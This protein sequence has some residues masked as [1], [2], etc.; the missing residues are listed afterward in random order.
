MLQHS[1]RLS[2]AINDACAASA[3]RQEEKSHQN[4]DPRTMA[5]LTEYS[6][7]CE[8]H[9]LIPMELPTDAEPT[10]DEVLAA[11]ADGTMEPEID[12]DDEPKWA[13]TIALPEREYWIA[14][15]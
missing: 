13:D 7:L 1:R 12:P 2:A 14:G 8:S 10:I 15:G 4:V 9:D 5:F 3:Q 6:P 11:I